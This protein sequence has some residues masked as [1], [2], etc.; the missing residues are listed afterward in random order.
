L[1]A[2]VGETIELMQGKGEITADDRADFVRGMTALMAGWF[3]ET[4]GKNYV[5]MRAFHP[6]MGPFTMT[7]QR[8]HGKTPVEQ[9][10]EA[11][12][13]AKQLLRL[14][15]IE[16]EPDIGDLGMFT[17][18]TREDWWRRKQAALAAL[19]PALRKLVES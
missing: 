3:K 7:I 2:R 8:T 1:L 9:R 12:Q 6:D 4:G 19:S 18:L 17:Q 16:N 14:L 15:R 10:D 13:I 5:E 11:R